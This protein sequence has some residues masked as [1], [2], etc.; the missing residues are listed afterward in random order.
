MTDIR[1]AFSGWSDLGW[2]AGPYKYLISGSVHKDIVVA[3][4]GQAKL[5]AKTGNDAF[6]FD[7]RAPFALTVT[8]DETA[9]RNAD[10]PIY[11]LWHAAYGYSDGTDHFQS[12]HLIL[13]VDLDLVNFEKLSLSQ[14]GDT[15]TDKVGT[16]NNIS[17]RAGNDTLDGGAGDDYL[18][19]GPGADTII[20]GSGSDFLRGGAGADTFKFSDFFGADQIFDFEPERHGDLIDLSDVSQISDFEDLKA[21]HV[22]QAGKD[23]RIEVDAENTIVLKNISIAAIGE[24]D[25]IF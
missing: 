21:N 25:F 24:D 2:I 13:F 18:K 14:L 22:V 7:H 10:A 4:G 3:S 9:T 6:Y 16:N 11:N 17:G 5:D 1:T 8:V 23:T 12:N 15:F 19:G 20:G